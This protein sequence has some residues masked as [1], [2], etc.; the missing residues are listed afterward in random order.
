MAA[1]ASE[2]LLAARLVEM[3]EAG[4]EVI[5][6]DTVRISKKARAEMV[7]LIANS[8]ASDAGM[9]AAAFANSLADEVERVVKSKSRVHVTDFP[10]AH[11]RGNYILRSDVVK[12]AQRI[13]L[14]AVDEQ[15]G[16]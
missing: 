10:N 1:E 3:H 5:G 6:G 9:S 7:A 4:I 11:Q 2:E 14:D 16:A 13:V 12:D 8:L 15:R